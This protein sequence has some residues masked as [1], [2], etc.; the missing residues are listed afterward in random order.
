MNRFLEEVVTNILPSWVLQVHLIVAGAPLRS[1]RAHLMLMCDACSTGFKQAS[2]RRK[3][4]TR[5]GDIK[6]VP[7]FA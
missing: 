1:L 6:D 4:A 3:S 7:C 2:G 5:Y